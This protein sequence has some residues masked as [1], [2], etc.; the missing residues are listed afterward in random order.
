M[1]GWL[2]NL[3]PRERWLVLGAAVGIAVLVLAVFVW[4][5]LDER[6]GMLAERAQ[7][8]AETLAWMEQASRRVAAAR[9]RAVGETAPRDGRSLLALVDATA[10]ERGLGD[11]LRRAEP[12][13]AG[14]VRVWL[15]SARYVD[16]AAWLEALS[17]RHGL[18]ITEVS[19]ERAGAGRVN[20]RLTVAESRT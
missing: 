4:L 6:R 2:D 18:A 10:R 19:L 3:A 14:G 16:L 12:A 15:E 11:M 13:D 17:G 5:P 8:R 1:S 20:A 9:E 7:S